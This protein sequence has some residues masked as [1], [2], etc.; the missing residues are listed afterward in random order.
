MEKHDPPPTPNHAA[1][2]FASQHTNPS[3][4]HGASADDN[5]STAPQYDGI[6]GVRHV[7]G[8][9][10]DEVP[11]AYHQLTIGNGDVSAEVSST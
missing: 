6:E 3:N 4:V 9:E 10:N 5:A 1:A 7:E 2:Y 8:A 11:P